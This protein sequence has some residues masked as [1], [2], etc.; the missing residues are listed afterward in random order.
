M[1]DARMTERRRELERLDTLGFLLDNSIR[2]PGTGLRFG[3]DPL[4][5]LVPGIGD[6]AG[7]LLSAWI[8]VKAAR[9]GAPVPSL[10][11][12]LLNVAVE[13]AVG[14]IPVAGDLFDAGWKA[15]AR[16][17]ALLRR[18]LQAPGS[19]RRGSA[20][21]VLGVVLALLLVLGAAGWAAFAIARALLG[22]IG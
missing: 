2:V 9:L 16:N 20:A 11:R 22:V 14:L 4:L 7:A 3:I 5:G 13:A 12:M 10:L 6:A 8:V 18:E 21:V 17:V 15:N 1:D 19:T